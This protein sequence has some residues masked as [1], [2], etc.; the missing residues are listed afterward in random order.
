MT[1]AA[2]AQGAMFERR[3]HALVAGLTLLV[4]AAILALVVALDRT[5][6]AVQSFDDR[7]LRWMT[8][9][10]TPW[11]TRVARIT[12]VLG[13]P[14]VMVP[15]RLTVIVAL[16]WRRRWLQFGAFVGATV[17]SELCIGPLKAL[18]DRPRPPGALITTDSSS[19]PSGHAIAASVTAFGLVVVLVP[20]ASRRTRWTIVAAVFAALMAMSR[21]YL[22]AHWASDVIAG[23][24][25]GTG[26]A[27]VWSAALELERARRRGAGREEAGRR[28]AGATPSLRVISVVLLS[29]GLACV[30]ALHLLRPDLGP[31]GH[32]ISEYANGP[33]GYVMTA[34]FV[35]IGAGLLAL[36]PALSQA[37]RRWSRAV[38]AAIVAAGIGMVAAGIWRTDPDRVGATTD[39]IHSHAS[40]A[41]TLVLIAA[42]LTWSV[43]VRRLDVAAGLAIAAAILGALSPALHRSGVTGVSQ[44]LLWLTLLAWLILTAWRLPD[45]SVSGHP[46]VRRGASPPETLGQRETLGWGQVRSRGSR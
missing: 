20:A 17:T 6:S 42:A 14:L 5:G 7:W 22:G 4:I 12:S 25:I 45:P 34:A 31:A 33:Y 37:G 19:F 10:R 46:S 11:L 26:L 36:G 8:D 3:L 35:S 2:G 21:T 38:A 32:R 43:V 44:R 18:I 9:L 29:L 13:G 30:V 40:A 23:A 1:R 16:A 39:A 41:A 27:A 15:L 28:S 24:C